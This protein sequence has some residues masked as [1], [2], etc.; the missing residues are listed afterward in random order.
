MTNTGTTNS[1]SST[2]SNATS[3]HKKLPAPTPVPAWLVR[4]AHGVM[5]PFSKAEAVVLHADTK[6][7]GAT[8]TLDAFSGLS[9]HWS[10][11]GNLLS[12]ST[13]TCVWTP[14]AIWFRLVVGF[15]YRLIVALFR[16]HSARLF[17]ERQARVRAGE[18]RWTSLCDLGRVLRA[19]KDQA[20]LSFPKPTL[21]R[22]A[23]AS[24]VN[25][26]KL[27]EEEMVEILRR[28]NRIMPL[29]PTQKLISTLR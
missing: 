20:R 3:R 17:A 21:R 19:A 2:T 12:E 11:T 6:T 13:W 23:P 10:G 16:G 15:L 8:Y 9:N 28:H 4:L 18:V 24:A 5:N 22:P 29:A 25:I 14:M 26:N 27:S 7:H 1:N